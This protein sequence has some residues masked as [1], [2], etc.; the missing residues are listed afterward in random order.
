M[1]QK[2]SFLFYLFILNLA[3]LVLPFITS[4]SKSDTTAVPTTTDIQLQVLNLSPDSYPVGLFI[5]NLRV[6][7]YYRYNVTPTYFYLT[8]TNYPLQIRTTRFAD[9]IQVYSND[10]VAFAP[11]TRYSLFFMGLY[12]DRTLQSVV[13]V[14]DAEPLPEIGK[15]GKIRFLNASPRSAGL[16][17][18]AND[19]IA[20]K[21]TAFAKVSGYVTLPAGNYNFKV[22]NTG[23]TANSITTLEKVTIQDGR[24]Y[25]LYARGMVGRT[26]S[27]AFSL[28]VLANNP[29]KK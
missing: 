6:N 10:T 21:N 27:A 17:V 15:G 8:N 14:D 29:P 18:F 26:D 19:L 11:N 5:N 3:V 13:T 23:T 2:R 28:G 1:V 24:L 4:C 20:M 16:D 22:F 25:T 12:S 9:S 7:A